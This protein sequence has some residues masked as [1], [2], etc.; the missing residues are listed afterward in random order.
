MKRLIRETFPEEPNVAVRVAELENGFRMTQSNLRY[1]KD[2]PEYGV[3]QGDRELS[4]CMFQIHEPAHKN[5][6]AKHGLHDYKTNVESCVKI[7]RIVYEQAGNSFSPWT[8]YRK[9]I[10]MR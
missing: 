8:V 7:A 5:T 10:A 3:K 6:I 2:R 1:T 9:Y 4:F